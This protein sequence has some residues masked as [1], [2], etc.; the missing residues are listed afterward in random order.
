MTVRSKFEPVLK[1]FTDKLGDQWAVALKTKLP[2]LLAGAATVGV[3]WQGAKLTLLFMSPA[4]IPES[5]VPPSS[6][7]PPTYAPVDAQRIVNAHLFG[8]FVLPA[9]SVDP[10]NLPVSQLNLLLAGTMASPDPEAGF[11]IVG[12]NANSAKFYRVGSTI[13]GSVRLHSVYS[14]LI[15]IDNAGKLETIKL[16]RGM[17][18][19]LPSPVQNP[20]TGNSPGETLRRAVNSNPNVLGELFRAQP[21]MVNGV[22]KGYRL[23]PGRDPI[24]FTRVGLQPGD[25]VTSVNGTVL[26]DIR[27]GTEVLNT[28]TSASTAQLVI[29]RNGASQNLVLDMSQLNLPQGSASQSSSEKSAT[30]ES[31]PRS[32]GLSGRPAANSAKAK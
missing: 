12:D 32:G 5:P 4:T 22:Q 2:Y 1:H 24:Q 16:P 30:S 13:S 11:A 6:L 9:E 31:G 19:T 20:I 29:E 27:R 23:F 28:L 17:L 3:A 10:N 18:A 21:V 8:N 26:D 15:V 14:N 7:P 25:L